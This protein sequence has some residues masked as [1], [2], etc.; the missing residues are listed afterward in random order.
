MCFVT[1]ASIFSKALVMKESL[2]AHVWPKISQCWNR[3]NPQIP[4]TERRACFFPSVDTSNARQ[5]ASR[6]FLIS[7]PHSCSFLLKSEKGILAKICACWQRQNDLTVSVVRDEKGAQQQPSERQINFKN[8]FLLSNVYL[9]AYIQFF[10]VTCHL[11]QRHY[12]DFLTLT[13]VRPELGLYF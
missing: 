10:N 4:Q 5:K 13:S 2:L 11:H 12:A 3:E 1:I 7:L 6:P 9:I 8:N